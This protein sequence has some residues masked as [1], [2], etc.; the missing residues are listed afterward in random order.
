MG[1]KIDAKIV[2]LGREYAGKTCLVERY[3]HGKAPG[4]N[5]YQNVRL[6]ITLN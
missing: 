5:P 2:L 1:S 4:S 3:L 6:L